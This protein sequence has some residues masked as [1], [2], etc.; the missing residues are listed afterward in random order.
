MQKEEEPNTCTWVNIAAVEDSSIAIKS[1]QTKDNTTVG[2]IGI[3]MQVF[4]D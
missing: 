1:T 2:S 4:P 3:I